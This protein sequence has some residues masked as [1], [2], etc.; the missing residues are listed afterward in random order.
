MGSTQGHYG[1]KVMKSYYKTINGGKN[2]K[3]LEIINGQEQQ[4]F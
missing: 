2:W 1:K 3:R 4:I